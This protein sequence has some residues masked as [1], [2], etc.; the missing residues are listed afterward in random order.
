[1]TRPD[2]PAVMD[3]R[4]APTA[5]FAPL[6]A[7][8]ALMAMAGTWSGRIETWLD[9]SKPAEL[10]DI[11]ATATV[12]LDGRWLQL[13]YQSTILDKP[14]AGQM[15]V[16]FHRDANEHE[17]AWIDTF[18][19]GTSILTSR[20]ALVAPAEVRV[21]GSYGAGQETWGWRTVIHLATPDELVWE[22]F[23]VAPSLHEERAIRARLRRETVG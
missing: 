4:S 15:T 20:G 18:H 10:H 21:V 22:A 16:G 12:I 9:P 23:N 13:C 8:V 11:T 7:H 3:L 1:M 17:I 6:E 5:P 2:S 19:T 14:L